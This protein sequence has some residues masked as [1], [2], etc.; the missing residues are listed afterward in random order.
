MQT[1]T[2]DNDVIADLA[3]AVRDEPVAVMTAGETAFVAVSP[4]EFERLV[5]F[6]RRRRQT[7]AKQLK[8]LMDDIG[9]QVA[10]T[11]TPEEIAEL[12]RMLIDED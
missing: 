8:Q 11:A 6:D 10:A 1:K 2:I 9:A 12:E 7:A 5:G 3:K 4:A